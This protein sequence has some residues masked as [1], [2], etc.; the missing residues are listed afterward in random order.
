VIEDPAG[1]CSN[2]PEELDPGNWQPASSTA[3]AAAQPA[4]IRARPLLQGRA[5]QRRADSIF[6]APRRQ[7]ADSGSSGQL[8]PAERTSTCG[9]D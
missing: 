8:A 1:A 7:T 6:I 9:Y 4:A 2:A 5:G 3:D